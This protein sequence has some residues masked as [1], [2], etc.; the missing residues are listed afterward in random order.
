MGLEFEMKYRATPEILTRIGA[1]FPGVY[2]VRQMT[3]AYYDTPDGALSARKWTL[4]C[5]QEDDTFV[6]TLKIPAA[7]GARGEWELECDDIHAAIPVLAEKA[8]LPEL[9]ELTK[10]GIEHT[11]GA[12]FVRRFREMVIG[13]TVAELALDQGVLTGGGNT[14]EFAEVELELKEG[15]REDVIRLASLLA[16]SYGLA[17]EPKSK[18]AR[19]RALRE[20]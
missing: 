18:V 2:T 4:R 17:Q 10:S 5:R 12:R 8:G 13:R 9:V 3:T 11:C 20:G 1:D 6:C 7:G 16:T 15:S 19:A 14:A